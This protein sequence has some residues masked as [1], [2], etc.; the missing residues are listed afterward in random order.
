MPALHVAHLISG[1]FLAACAVLVIAG[2]GKVRRPRPARAAARAAGLRLPSAA[3]VALA[4]VEIGAGLGGAAFGGRVA[5]LV[6]ACY[7]LLTFVAVRLLRRA[8]TTPCACLGSSTA[9]VTPVHVV[10]DIVGAGVAVAATAGGSPLNGIAGHWI[11]GAIFLALVAC[12]VQLTT[13]TLG[14][15]ADLITAV[16]T[17]A[18]EGGTA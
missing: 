5:W 18:V 11:E 14:A 12:C 4:L 15:M 6:A 9:V 7:V 16:K 8:P 10:I 1:P 2:A 3:I 13:L 17:G